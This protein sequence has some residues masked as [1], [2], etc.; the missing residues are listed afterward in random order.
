[1]RTYR[2]AYDGFSLEALERRVLHGS[3]AG[4]NACAECCDRWAGDG[5]VA[6]DWYGAQGERQQVTFA[7]LQDDAARFA[8]LLTQRGIRPGD[9]VAGLMPRIPELLTVVMGTWRAGAVYQPL[10][11]A[12]GPK[13]IEDRVT[14][15]QG[16]KAK[17]ILTDLVN[18]PKLDDVA[19]C[20]P[21]LLVDRGDRGPGGFAAMLAAQPAEFAPVMRQ[22]SDPFILIFTSGT[23]G[24]AK[25]VAAPL[26]MLLQFAVMMQDGFDL[27]ESDVFWCFADPGWA[28]GMYVTLTT[29]LLLGHGT[30]LFEGAFTVDSIVRTIAAAG[31][32]NLIAAP[33]VFRM[34]RAAGD[35]AMAPIAGQLRRISS[36]G[37]PLNVEMSRWG[38]EVLGQPIHE[39]YGQ[40]EM[41]VN[42]CNHLGIS[43]RQVPGSVG[44]PSP[45]FAF[46]ILDD[47]LRPAP[48]GETG[49]LAVD[50]TRSPLFFFTGYWNAE[51]PAFRDHWYL[52]GDTMRQDADGYLYFIS[53]NDDIITSAGYRIGPA[54]VEGAI[55][56]HPAVAE[57]AV[58]GK[59]DP[60]R[61][62]IVKA[63]IVLRQGQQASDALS[64]AIQAHVRTRLSLHAYPRE[65][66][67]LDELPKT[68][69]GKVQRFVL[70]QRDR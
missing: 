16:S 23:T 51:T 32:T 22:G 12:F 24:R 70:R 2:D 7:A 15:P 55:I 19:D 50:R 48:T 43:H 63:F 26:K 13:A 61:T 11:T 49:V 59:P 62:E 8:N 66:E 33:T 38:E 4:L 45:G 44:L 20:P 53:R 29:P 1:M 39:V 67:Y 28:L 57:V 30:V 18:R 25:G 6:L 3:L 14:G 68:P 52:T 41:G 9:V 17:L 37:E 60:E 56:E 42:V 58:V 5:R 64:A 31:V 47:D 40:T 54:D 69:S 34:L 10:F 36:G 21:V 27:Q 65:I 46:A 35:V